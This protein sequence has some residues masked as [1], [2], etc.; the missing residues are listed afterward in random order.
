MHQTKSYTPAPIFIG[1]IPTSID[2]VSTSNI[3]ASMG[4]VSTSNIPASIHEDLAGGTVLLDSYISLVSL[5][6]VMLLFLFSK[7]WKRYARNLTDKH[8]RDYS[9]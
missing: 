4:N 1:N 8:H 7:A 9:R 5:V 6:S 2:N 3:P